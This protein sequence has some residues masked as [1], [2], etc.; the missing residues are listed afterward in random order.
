MGHPA[1]HTSLPGSHGEKNAL[2]LIWERRERISDPDANSLGGYQ[3]RI[4]AG[5]VLTCPAPTCHHVLPVIQINSEFAAGGEKG[6]A[7]MECIF[8]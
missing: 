8:L 4:V 2:S 3:S 7:F 1:Q 6:F 5:A